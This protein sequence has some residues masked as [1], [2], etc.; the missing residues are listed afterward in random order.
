MNVKHCHEGFDEEKKLQKA[1]RIGSAY[2]C[3]HCQKKDLMKK[4]T[5]K[6]TLNQF[7]RR[8]KL[9]NFTFVVNDLIDVLNEAIYR[10]CL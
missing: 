3:E 4:K 8:R 6:G 9:R 5:S 10:I 1:Y 2:E 7:M